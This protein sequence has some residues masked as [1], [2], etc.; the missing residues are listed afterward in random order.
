MNTVLLPM[1]ETPRRE[2][3]RPQFHFTPERNW[4]NDP[5]G[6]VYF[7]GE[8]HLFYQYN[9]FANKWGHMSWGHAVSR[10]LLHWVELPVALPE[11]GETMIYS[12]SAVVDWENTSGFG[13]DGQPPLVAIYT[14]HS[15]DPEQHTW[16]E[17]QRLAFSM[18]HGRTWTRFS[19]NP[20]IDLGLPDFRDP[21]VFWHGAT[22]RWIL[23]VAIPDKRKIRLYASPDL[24]DW[25][26]LSEFGQSDAS[27]DPIIWEC[28]D[29]FPLEIEGEPGVQKWV[30]L[31]ST[32]P[33]G[34]AGGS[35][36]QY[37]VGNFDGTR[38]TPDPSIS[39]QDPMWLDYGSDFYAAVT[40]S[41]IPERD[42]RRILL[43]WMNNWNYAHDVPTSPWRGG[44]TVPRTLELA[45]TDQGLRLI[46]KPIDELSRLR[47]EPPLVFSG[48]SLAEAAGWLAQKGNL[49]DLLDV[50]MSFSDLSDTRFSIQIHTATDESTAIEIDP[51]SGSL[52]V[53]RS[54]S[55]VQEFHPAFAGSSRHKAPLHVYDGK[56][57]LRILMDASSLE[58]FT[59]KG[60]TALT[61]LIFP[62]GTGCSISLTPEGGTPFSIPGV[63]CISIHILQSA[64]TR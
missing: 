36:M 6:L 17:D 44:M 58:I 47:K 22:N 48:G 38:F 27:R 52:F 4:M 19:G 60:R 39:A 56:L 43:G 25:E 24:K 35:G 28:P 49:P 3:F 23:T 1:A 32:N 16:R 11:E 41:D 54:Q 46:Q 21:K 26:L 64:L 34:P 62:R 12:G 59:Q 7:E 50:E 29:M 63:D 15:Y 40:W 8:Y 13:R 45:R 18:D 37:F 9:P 5:N 20:V 14:G 33:G 51:G 42:G 30:L 10:D 2:A 57:A 61:D 55:G 53:D 31:V